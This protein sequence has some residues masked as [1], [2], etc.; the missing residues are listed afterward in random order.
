VTVVDGRVETTPAISGQ[1]LDLTAA[2]AALEARSAELATNPTLLLSLSVV[3]LQP[4]IADVSAVAQE[5]GPLLAGEMTVALW[6]PVRDEHFAWTI[7]PQDKGHW[8]TFATSLDAPGQITWRVD[9]EK[10]GATVNA[11]EATLGPARYVDRNVAIPAILDAF[12]AG[13]AR[14][15]NLRVHHFDR[16]HAVQS[17]ETVSSIGEDYGVPYPWILKANPDLGDNLQVGQEIVV[18]SP[19]ALLPLP[20]VE[21]KRI[22]VS[23]G[24][25]HL[26]AFENGQ[27]KFDWVISTGLPDSPTSPGVF[28]VQTH[29]GTAY[30]NQWDL[31]MPWFMGIYKPA[32]DGEVMNGFHGFPSRDQKQLLWTKNLGR[33]VTYGCILLSTE[34]AET[35]YQWADEGVIVEVT[36]S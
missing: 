36:K 8:L 26:Q 20:P 15:I 14:N 29:E 22:V 10:V 21:N 2:M 19:D 6:D 32:A 34:N 31:H 23:I 33:P 4:S 13:G 30:A 17:G 5:I 16:T 9:E 24:K 25:Q 12:R 28:Q 27:L 11:Q 7:T 35:L 1:A 18:P 3:P